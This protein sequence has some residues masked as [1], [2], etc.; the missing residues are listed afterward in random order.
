LPPRGPRARGEFTNY[1][2]AADALSQQLRLC[3]DLSLDQTV[4]EALLCT[5]TIAAHRGERHDAGLLAGAASTRFE[6]RRRMTA[7]ELVF[8]RIEDQL[9]K[10]ARDTDPQSWDS[11]ARAGGALG[12]RDAIGLALRALKD[13]PAQATVNATDHTGAH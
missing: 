2:D 6:K 3:R 8:R 12:D 13:R 10:A 5:A 11:A 4:E 9:L 7:E 1:E